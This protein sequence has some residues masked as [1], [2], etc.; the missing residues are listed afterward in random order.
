MNTTSSIKKQQKNEVHFAIRLDWLEKKRGLVTSDEVEDTIRV[1]M[2]PVF[3]GE[4]ATENN[5]R[6][7]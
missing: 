4:S 6:C 7:L 5:T 3:G 1:A 2:P